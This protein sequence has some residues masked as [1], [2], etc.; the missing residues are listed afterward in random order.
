MIVF[1]M[2]MI[3]PTNSLYCIRYLLKVYFGLGSSPLWPIAAEHSEPHAL[4][5]P[6]IPFPAP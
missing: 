4:G 3:V 2:A 5:S 1:H 6:G